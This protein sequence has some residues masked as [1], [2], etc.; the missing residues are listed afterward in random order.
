[1]V[2]LLHGTQYT[3][4]SSGSRHLECPGCEHFSILFSG[5]QEKVFWCVESWSWCTKTSRFP[6]KEKAEG[7][8]FNI[9]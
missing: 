1:M 7:P 6:K 9:K 5:P 4:M 3:V 2:L 8:I